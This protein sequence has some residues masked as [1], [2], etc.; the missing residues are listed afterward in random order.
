MIDHIGIDVRDLEASKT[1]YEQALAPLVDE[2]LLVTKWG[3]TPRADVMLALKK[4]IEARADLSGVVLTQ[5]EM[6]EAMR[7]SE[8]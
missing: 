1:F 3:A 4:L 7:Q 8:S 6:G 2:V 5:V